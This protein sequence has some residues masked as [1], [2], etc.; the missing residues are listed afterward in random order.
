MRYQQ[1]S[2]PDL[3]NKMGETQWLTEITVLPPL[4]GFEG[5]IVAISIG[6]IAKSVGIYLEHVGRA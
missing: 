3:S 1:I 4:F 2:Q 5:K 6:E